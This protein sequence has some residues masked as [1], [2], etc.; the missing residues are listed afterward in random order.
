M[1]QV[2]L[3]LS[4]A[5]LFFYGYALAGLWGVFLGRGR[6]GYVLWGLTGGTVSAV[7]ALWLWNRI[8]HRYRS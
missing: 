5:T 7:A 4:I 2:V 8:A 1:R 3:L 6:W